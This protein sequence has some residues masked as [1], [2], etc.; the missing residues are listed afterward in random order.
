MRSSP[1]RP[2]REPIL[3]LPAAVAFG[4]LALVAIHAGRLL[5][6]EDTDFQ[7]IIDW[8]VIPARWSVAFGGVQA[9][10]VMNSLKG[11]VPD[12]A[13]SP[14]SILAQYVLNEGEGRPWTGLTYA[15]LHG[16]W[17]HVLINCV[18]LAAFGTP[19]ARRCGAWRFFGLAAASALGGAILYTIVNPLQILPMIGASAA[20]SGMMAAASWFMF[21]PADWLV[22]EGRMTQPHE[23]LREGLADIVRNRQVLIFLG[24]WFVANYVFAFVQPVGVTDASIAWEAHIGGFLV[25]LALFPLLDPLPTRPSRISA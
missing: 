24:V 17:A 11:S 8:A 7:L 9:E 6:S 10:E 2:A 14:L 13:V 18:W 21:A 3:N 15:F 12:E 20:V 19:I 22:E 4:V 25:G 5:L 1:T 16:S 23:R